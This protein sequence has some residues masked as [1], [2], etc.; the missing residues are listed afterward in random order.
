M[1][2]TLKR[3]AD[4]NY[5]DQ[6]VRSPGVWETVRDDA[7]P[8][9]E[10][11]TLAP[12]LKPQNIFLMVL[13]GETPAGFFAFCQSE[14]TTYEMHTNLLPICR[15]AAAIHAAWQAI[16]WLFNHT[17]A[18]QIET[19]VFETARPA[20]LLLTLARWRETARRLHPATVDGHPLQEIWFTF[21][22]AEW[23]ARQP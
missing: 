20:R 4:L 10:E 6:V 7:T 19:Y 18:Q 15:G 11:F 14:K 5:L 3:T 13:L 17:A 2:P 1:S 21:T 22:R 9:R 8:P 12:I 23:A 16:A